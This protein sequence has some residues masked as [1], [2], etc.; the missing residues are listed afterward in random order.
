MKTIVLAIADGKAQQVINAIPG[1]ALLPIEHPYCQR[2]LTYQ[3]NGKL[4]VL[5]VNPLRLNVSLPWQSAG[6]SGDWDIVQLTGDPGSVGDDAT[7]DDSG[8]QWVRRA[9]RKLRRL[10]DANPT[11]LRGP[12]TM[13]QLRDQYP[14]KAAELLDGDEESPSP[15]CLL[16]GSTREA[17]EVWEYSPTQQEID[18]DTDWTPPTVDVTR[19][20]LGRFRREP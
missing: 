9:Y 2:R 11:Y 15:V 1:L 7:E 16:A 8:G 20:S 19:V 13:Q 3:R 14:A 6:N 10:S 5:L 12:W 17:A 18:N 4:I